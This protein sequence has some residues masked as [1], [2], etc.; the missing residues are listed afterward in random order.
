MNN[1]LFLFTIGPVQSFI[2]QARKTQDLYAGSQI[3]SCLVRASIMAFKQEFDNSKVIFPTF[4]RE[5]SAISLPNRFVAK[6]ASHTWND[7]ELKAK[8][9]KIQKAIVKEFST[10]ALE[11]LGRAGIQPPKGFDEQMKTHVDIFWAFQEIRGDFASAYK[12]L[13]SLVGSIK[14]VRP[15][16][17]YAYTGELGEMG[18]KCSIDGVN[19]ALIYRP[20][21]N[22][23]PPFYIAKEAIP[24]QSF[25]LNPGEGLSA[26]SFVKR[27][28][29][30]AD[31]FPSTAE[32]ALMHDETQLSEERKE[33][34]RCYKM[35][36]K[37]KKLIE[38][39]L[40]MFKNGWLEKAEVTTP[41][42]NDDWYDQS[43]D[44]QMLYEENLTSKIIPVAVQLGLVRN[45]HA[46]L[47]PA[48]KTKYYAL[49]LF[50]GDKMGEW[51][52]GENNLTKDNLEDFHSKLSSL[53]SDFGSQAYQ[54]LN[55]ELGNGHAVYAGGD[56]FMG[57]VNIH[58]LF[59]VMKKLREGFNSSVNKKLANFKQA[60]KHLTFSAG[61]VIA[62]YKTPFTEVLKKAREIEKKAKKEGGRN[63]FGIT[64]LKHSGEV[65]EAV[66]K[67]DTDEYSPDGCA[68]WD[69]LT[70]IFSELDKE[71]GHF[72]GKFIQNLTT[73]FYQLTGI[74]LLEIDSMSR[75]AKLIEQALLSEIERLVSR[76]LDKKE[77][78]EK[79]EKRVNDLVRQ[80][81]SLWKHALHPKTENFIHAL[82][83]VDFLTRKTTQS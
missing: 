64:V 6:I 50:D 47:K 75:N 35:L 27:F 73:E 69:A 9:Q 63:A 68:N 65:Q 34:L 52:A 28:Y 15:F 16:E 82:Q 57:F 46:R 66:Y 59:D 78:P 38:A 17:Q 36:F 81:Q 43:D 39:C 44:Y 53:L 80:V 49:I 42:D 61:I 21:E 71:E 31:S 4:D 20:R 56:D 79:D 8:A 22:G 62:H 19:N 24:L 29:P 33:M 37:K 32:V 5:A 40:A 72:S 18:R 77:N 48:F 25:A 83:I 13:E 76:S 54:N 41:A 26:V 67:W 55:R 45:L 3:L 1:H 14:N 74:D 58:H 12:A 51:L 23:R 7:S 10:I 11:S 70:H 2:A 60:D 30:N